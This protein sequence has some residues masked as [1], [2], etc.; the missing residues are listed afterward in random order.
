MD[1][2]KEQVKNV[3]EE[4]KKEEKVLAIILCGSR[5][6]GYERE[7]SDIDICVVA[8]EGGKNIF[9]KILKLM[10]NER[11]DIKLF[12][13]LPLFLKIKIIEEGK[14]IFVRDENKLF[15]Y[16][17]LIRKIWEDEKIASEKISKI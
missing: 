17:S 8:P 15:E 7:S 5:E 2:I 6:K 3:I 16:F 12:E 14:A 1:E 10:Q 4:L 9:E 13:D 11:I